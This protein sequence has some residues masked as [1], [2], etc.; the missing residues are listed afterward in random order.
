MLKLIKAF[1]AREILENAVENVDTIANQN[2]RE[3]KKLIVCRN[4]VV[5]TEVEKEGLFVTFT[6][7]ATLK[8]DS[9]A[10]CMSSF[11]TESIFI[12]MVG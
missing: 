7:Y 12:Y 4:W 10:L 9:R 11:G 5:G 8:Y 3:I 1:I 6:K 2:K